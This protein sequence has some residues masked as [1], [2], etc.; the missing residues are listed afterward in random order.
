MAPPKVFHGARA[1]F[2]ILD[3]NTGIPQTVGIF[4]NC[5]YGLAYTVQPAYI[6][7]RFS[8]AELGYTAQEPVNITCAGW[9]VIGAGP[10]AAAAV[11]HLQDLLFH[12]Y[13]TMQVVDRQ[14]GNPIATFQ[15]V[16]PTGYNT[17][18]Q[19]RQ[20]ETDTINFMGILVDDESGDNAETVSPVPAA[21]LP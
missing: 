21:D 18:I 12:E 10:H 3:P 2:Q 5:S 17:S 11:P 14:T 1:I 7:G 4:D 8:A 19:A 20:L 15:S 6:L 9:R 16:R 13:I